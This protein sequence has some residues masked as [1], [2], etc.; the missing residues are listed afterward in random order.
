MACAVVSAHGRLQGGLGV[1]DCS[2]LRSKGGPHSARAMFSE[3]Q[4]R[5][6]LEPCHSVLWP[7]VGVDFAVNVIGAVGGY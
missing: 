4:K 6:P 1:I 2:I 5:N 7:L 3:Q